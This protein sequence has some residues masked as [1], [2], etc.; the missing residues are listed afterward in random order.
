MHSKLVELN[1]IHNASIK[2]QFIPSGKVGEQSST[3]TVEREDSSCS[4]DNE[5]SRM[6]WGEA[7]DEVYDIGSYIGKPWRCTE[8]NERFSERSMMQQLEE[9]KILKKFVLK[10]VK[11]EDYNKG[12]DAAVAGGIYGDDDEQ[13]YE[14]YDSDNDD[15]D[16]DISVE[17]DESGEK[18]KNDEKTISVNGQ[19]LE[20]HKG[21]RKEEEKQRKKKLMEKKAQLKQKAKDKKK[22][23]KLREPEVI[24]RKQVFNQQKL[25]AR[26]L[27]S[28]E[29]KC[30]NN[31]LFNREKVRR[32]WQRRQ[33]KYNLDTGEDGVVA[34]SDSDGDLLDQL[35]D[36]SAIENYE[37][38]DD[39][40]E[41]VVQYRRLLFMACVCEARL[42]P[43]HWT[44]GWLHE[45]LMECVGNNVADE[46]ITEGMPAHKLLLHGIRVIEYVKSITKNGLNYPSGLSYFT[47]RL[48]FLL[49]SINFAMRRREDELE[50]KLLNIPPR[51][52]GFDQREDQINEDQQQPTS[53][54]DDQKQENK[55]KD[56]PFTFP[57][58]NSLYPYYKNLSMKDEIIS[59]LGTLFPDTYQY[60]TANSPSLYHTPPSYRPLPP[61]THTS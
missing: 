45:Q 20:E 4:H 60:F 58:F 36:D 44:V 8:C 26:D 48:A 1:Q 35:S 50:R 10:L 34:N 29:E 41:A 49:E 2:S 17:E 22:K 18:V 13:R 57:S 6:Y 43:L 46:G 12:N 53:L 28:K 25:L 32:N 38:D 40:N 15:D 59:I 54:N 21:Q 30:L 61:Y 24:R 47:L 9:E 7:V 37:E 33:N 52:T 11:K 14:Q 31:E 42:G 23:D 39:G 51:N 19:K 16:F 3:S 55:A 5:N 27:L 56:F